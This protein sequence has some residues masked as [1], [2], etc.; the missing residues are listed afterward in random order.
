MWVLSSESVPFLGGNLAF[1]SSSSS[2]QQKYWRFLEPN[3]C[4]LILT[5]VLLV[6]G[7]VV[8]LSLMGVDVGPL[9]QQHRK[10]LLLPLSCC[11]FFYAGAYDTIGH[12][13]VN[14]TVCIQH[15]TFNVSSLSRDWL[16]NK[17]L[18]YR[19]LFYPHPC[20]YLLLHPPS[21]LCLLWYVGI[22]L[23]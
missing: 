7:S 5:E 14:L 13:P 3:F 6:A 19:H 17:A 21:M 18:Q 16:A 2:S 12:M 10:A 8:A 15:L 9:K 20:F 1:I 4:F 22:A 11:S 23:V